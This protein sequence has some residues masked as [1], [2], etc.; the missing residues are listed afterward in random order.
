MSDTWPGGPG[1]I[2]GNVS[3]RGA[4]PCV[5]RIVN[6]HD[7][8]LKDAADRQAIVPSLV[9]KLSTAEKS[10][11]A[12]ELTAPPQLNELGSLPDRRGEG[13]RARGP[14]IS[15]SFASSHAF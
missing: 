14:H 2:N 3:L 1:A 12:N 10:M 5:F 7:K 11:L 6:T 15:G 9:E 4:H 13:H 8:A